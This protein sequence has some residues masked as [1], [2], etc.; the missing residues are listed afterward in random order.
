MNGLYLAASGAASTLASLETAT[1]NLTNATTPGFRRLFTV[2]QAMSGDGSPYEYAVSGGSP[3][4]DMAQGPVNRTG[5]PLDVG[6]T[7]PGFITVQT[8]NGEAY[9]RDGEL[10]VAPNGTLMAAGYPVATS[11]GGALTL[12]PG[13]I[14]IN[15]SGLVSVNG[16]AL[17]QIAL[18][19]PSGVQMEPIGRGLY[20][21]VGGGELPAGAPGTEFHQGFLEG[22]T[23]TLVGS[24]LAVMNA[25]RSYQA[26]MN[27][28]HSINN[29]QQR[30]I[31]TLTMQA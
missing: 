21:P 8:P 15:R 5:N 4:I 25:M 30:A 19:D 1:T 7:G 23:G 13:T 2:V 20:V 29:D 10:S 14:T 26:A 18:G 27:A 3:A 24:M 28:V 12:T 11:G 16:D 22:S 17:G 6:L 31:Q 9:T